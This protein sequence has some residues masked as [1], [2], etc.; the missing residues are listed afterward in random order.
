M[1]SVKGR[2]EIKLDILCCKEVGFNAI[3]TLEKRK[4]RE[5]RMPKEEKIGKQ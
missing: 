5:V 4:S 1:N 2:K 3:F